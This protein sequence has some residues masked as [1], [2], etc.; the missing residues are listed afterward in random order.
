MRLQGT[1]AVEYRFTLIIPLY[2]EG[3]KQQQ[4]ATLLGCSQAWVSK[5]LQ[6]YKAQGKRGLK[7]KVRARG[8]KPLLCAAQMR[9]LKTLLL[10][11]ALWQ[12][13]TTDN[14]T[15]ERIARLI[16]K[17]FGI[18]YSAAHISRLMRRIGF[19]VQKPRRASFKKDQ[20][21]VTRWKEQTLPA[22]KKKG[23]NRTLSAALLR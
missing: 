21:Q 19:T 23:T 20:Q 16:E 11:G 13:F 2:K 3:K 6:R 9:R 4:I 7:V 18:H 1:H 10:K 22:L 14:W 17:H 5:V 8:K 15:R 12:G